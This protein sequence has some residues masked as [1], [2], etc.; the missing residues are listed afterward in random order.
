MER[1]L[2]RTEQIQG[3]EPK[4]LTFSPGRVLLIRVNRML[5]DGTAEVSAGGHRFI[6]GVQTGLK[7]GESYWVETKQN[8]DGIGLSVLTGRPQRDGGQILDALLSHYALNREGP[9]RELIGEAL[10]LNVPITK[11]MIDFA[12]AMGNRLNPEILLR[13]ER[14]HLPFTDRIYRSLEAGGKQGSLLTGIEGLKNELMAAGSTSEAE[15]LMKNVQAPLETLAGGKVADRA[16]WILADDAKPFPLRL[17]ALDLL[18]ELGVL[19]DNSRMGQ[20]KEELVKTMLKSFPDAAA[21]EE[22]LTKLG[23]GMKEDGAA[24]MRR[25]SAPPSSEE[26]TSFAR[27]VIDAIITAKKDLISSVHSPIEV[28]TAAG[29][30]EGRDGTNKDSLHS[31]LRSIVLE[32]LREVIHG[33]D[34]SQL[35]KKAVSSLGLN[36]ESDPLVDSA[37]RQL[38]QLSQSHPSA[39]IRERA[40]E[41]VLKMNHPSLV[42]QDQSGFLTIVHQIPL[43]H[44]AGQTDMTI[45]WSGKKTD[46]GQI[47][48]SHCRVMFYLHLGNLDETI[49]D[50]QIQQRVLQIVVWNEHPGLKDLALEFLPALKKGVEENGY[51][52][53]SI[54]FKIPESRPGPGTVTDQ[55]PAGH[56]GVDIRI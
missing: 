11:T 15:K 18:K 1:I 10:R 17:A 56:K 35:L 39:A 16:L 14:Q 23:A 2:G 43:Y 40:D 44:T 7:A 4:P 19:P 5:G 21:A 54:L 52:F 53:S 27:R 32:E 34:I 33:R 50:L 48:S 26:L 6:A 47:D 28:R 31:Q 24:S 22:G 3:N 42:S 12:K 13:M 41:I 9:V 55:H 30:L 25:L 49:V 45:Q 8:G 37:K 29:Q 51:T 38:I 20:W 36:Y 46:D